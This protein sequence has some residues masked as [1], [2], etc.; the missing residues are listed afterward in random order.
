MLNES[1]TDNPVPVAGLP[2]TSATK[3]YVFL[4]NKTEKIWTKEER[5]SGE[6]NKEKEGWSNNASMNYIDQRNTRTK[7]VTL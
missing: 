6:K 2:N 3:Q 4:R 7:R 5:E 1:Y